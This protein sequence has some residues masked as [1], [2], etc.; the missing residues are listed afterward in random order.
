MNKLYKPLLFFTFF[1]IQSLALFLF[2]QAQAFENSSLKPSFNQFKNQNTLSQESQILIKE[3][4]LQTSQNEAVEAAVSP[5]T[6][7]NFFSQPAETKP[8]VRIDNKP[9]IK[10]RTNTAT[11][12]DNSK[13]NEVS[14]VFPEKIQNKVQQTVITEKIE[15]VKEEKP[16]VEAK[17]LFSTNK[18]FHTISNIDFKQEWAMSGFSLPESTASKDDTPYIYLSNVNTANDTGFI[19]RI[20]KDGTD[21]ERHW[22]TGLT[23][24][25]GMLMDDRKLYVASQEKVY[26]VDTT[27][28]KVTNMLKAKKNDAKNI[29]SIALSKDDILYASDIISGKIYKQDGESLIEWFQSD[30]IKYPNALAINDTHLLVANYGTSLSKNISEKEYGSIYAIDLFTREVEEISSSYK[31]G[32]LESI[33]PYKQGFI[34]TS[35]S[36]QVYYI[37]KNNRILL[38]TLSEGIT[39]AYVSSDMLYIVYLKHNRLLAYK[40]IQK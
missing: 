16:V 7:E 14:P 13:I 19:S 18:I 21:V 9:F 27:R 36:G 1:T 11:T 12:E 15:E 6:S 26:I 25:T 17:I 32:A 28:A 4:E 38:L 10:P 30:S 39:D 34:V 29:N 3:Q 5:K 40:I 8:Q 37:D 35:V 33:H 31:L 22:L 23:Q 24:P 2:N 20:K